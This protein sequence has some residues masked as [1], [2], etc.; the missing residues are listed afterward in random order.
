MEAGIQEQVAFYLTGQRPGAG[1]QAVDALGLRPALLVRYRDLT[2][3]RYDFPIVLV[4]DGRTGPTRVQ[5]LSAVV[6]DVV[7]AVADGDDGARLARSALR[8]EQRVRAAV[9]AG[10]SGSLAALWDEATATVADESAR[11]RAALAVDGEVIDCDGN[12]PSRIL[13]HMWAAT[14]QA[15]AERARAEID[16]L[17]L[18]LA[19]ILR[20]DDAH[21]EAG[22]S[23]ESLR[24]AV[25]TAHADVFDFEAMS[26]LLGRSPVAPLPASRRRRIVRLIAVLESQQFFP[27]ADG[28]AA[29]P[30]P[31]AF[32]FDDC[33]SVLAAYRERLPRAIELARAIAIAELEIDS[34]YDEARHDALFADFGASG[35]DAQES[36]R[37]PDYLVCLDAGQLHGDQ[38]DTLLEMLATGLPVK[39]L[40]QTG[41]LLD[42]LGI[43]GST[44]LAAGLRNRQI[45]SAAI[46]LNDIYVLQ[47]SASH[48]YQYR[49][50]VHDGLNGARPALFSIFSGASGAGGIPPYLIAAAAME[51]RAF[52]A[53][54]YDPAAGD[55]WAERFAIEGNPQA[56]LDWPVQHFQYEEAH[57]ER[58][59]T[60]IPFTFVDF[61]AMDSRFSRH[62]AGL[63]TTR[64][65]GT[66]VSV[67]D[68]LTRE[69]N[70]TPERV[71]SI[72][73]VDGEDRLH[74]VVIDDAL[75]DAAKR[76]R[77]AWR[78]LQERGGIHNSHAERLLAREREAWEAEHRAAAMIAPV[79][80]PA[81]TP[82]ATAAATPVEA[83]VLVEEPADE[84][85]RS[86][87]EAWI[88]SERCT[89]CNECTLI[90]PRMFAYDENRQ[91][92]IVDINAGTYRDL[93]EAAENCQ[94]AIIHPGKPRNPN[95]P[96]LEDLIKRAAPFL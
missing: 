65:N 74:T 10:A 49:E 69:P 84:P 15:K 1:L 17:V 63:S 32:A 71:P 33:A 83:S 52:P 8:I 28:A 5:S 16:R 57:H 22:R 62:F 21:S 54:V 6:D 55:T 26:R 81:P 60:T 27:A 36:A 23:A 72:M 92:H 41:D 3:L 91:S 30:R 13:H 46:D 48:L 43:G 37:F 2:R 56:T 38:R 58:V 79:S 78:S 96:G 76:C 80:A 73:M 45:T 19:D 90:N 7:R 53:F 29:G 64:P 66:I 44:R 25:G 95:E 4:S 85:V 94:V 61:V 20:V 68:Y 86:P 35:L 70:G 12:A 40:L 77:A 67:D 18:K 51:S 50:R 59:E 31:Y 9:A 14:Q 11:L 89:T 24:A 47:A 39:V 34:Q 93:V 88:E 82:A 87:D 75:I 42:E